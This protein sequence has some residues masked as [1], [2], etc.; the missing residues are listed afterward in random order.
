MR[1][2]KFNILAKRPAW[3]LILSLLLLATVLATANADP[4]SYTGQI[5]LGDGHTCLLQFDGSV[6]CYGRSR[7]TGQYPGG[8]QSDDHPGP[9]KYITSGSFHNCGI[10]A[11]D[12]AVCWGEDSYGAVSGNPGG[13]WK[14]IAAGDAF[15]CGL[16]FTGMVEC[17]GKNNVG[18]TNPD[19]GPFD[20]IELGGNHACG[21]RT[22]GSMGCWGYNG[23]GLPND[24]A[25]G[26][27]L[28]RSV[29][30]LQVCVLQADGSA[31]CWGYD[32]ANHPGPFIDIEAGYR[33]TCA[34]DTSGDATCWGGSGLVS[35]SEGPFVQLFVG[36]FHD[37][38]IL[39]TDG[40]LKCWGLNE[41]GEAD[42]KENPFGLPTD[43]DGDGVLDA[44]DQCADT[45][46]SADDPESP[47]KNRFYADADGNF[48]DGDGNLS[49]YTIADTGG[50]SRQQIIAAA[51]LGGG[52]ERFGISR[53][54]LEAWIASVP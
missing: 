39:E 26:T 52:H 9:F 28:D 2:S 44:D 35:G 10:Y 17:W 24:V 30:H 33:H 27:Y 31:S 16:R 47:K 11:D 51:G 13:T 3:V 45:D 53:S 25:P 40:S 6:D 50:C 46:L 38:G 34:L 49:G 4:G 41:Y 32:T 21:F 29:G 14:Q 15:T 1:T 36:L 37:C 43:A 22:D 18:Q 8:S 54:A 42:A 20:S 19:A 23:L 48:V 5:G 12:T 7:N